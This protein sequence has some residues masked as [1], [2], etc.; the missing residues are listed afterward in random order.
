[1][2]LDGRLAEFSL[3]EVFQ[4]LEHGNKTGLLTLRTSP[5]N[6]PEQ[7]QNHYIWLQQ[8]QIVAAA[9]R[10]DSQGLSIMLKQR[11]WIGDCDLSPM[12]N[13]LSKPMGTVLKTEGI[14]Q[15]ENLKIL[16]YIQVMQQVCTL[17]E[18][19]DGYFKFDNQ[20][21]LPFL[22]M[23]GLSAP[24]TEVTL[25]GLRALKKWDA[26]L[27]K[28]P[29]TTSGLISSIE[30]KPYLHLNQQ[31]W[32]VWEF[33]DG[34]TSVKTISQHLGIPII[35]IQRIAFRLIAVNLCEE[36]PL[37]DIKPPKTEEEVMV[38]GLEAKAESSQN[39]LSESFVQ[40]LI[41]FL[42]GKI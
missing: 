29:D 42:Q 13:V 17:F 39:D 41:G 26:L 6:L 22:E 9:N 28:L 15:P 32:Q 37:V 11:N 21:S 7:V 19:Q 36:M 31:E 27:E 8:G 14:I 30:D 38:S 3:P 20:A 33:V 4:L 23:T 34:Q 40:N 5:A 10:L 1:M 35:D 24:A 18:F 12:F 2:S 16:F 25:A